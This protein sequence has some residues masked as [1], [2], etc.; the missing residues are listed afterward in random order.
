MFSKIPITVLTDIIPVVIGIAEVIYVGLGWKIY[1]EFGWK[2]YKLLG[3]D[4]Q[5]KKMYAQYQVFECLLK[6]DVFFWLGFSIQVKSGDPQ[7]LYTASEFL[8]SF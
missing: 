5:I 1:T 4:R 3:A 7:S 2:V 6:F 8:L